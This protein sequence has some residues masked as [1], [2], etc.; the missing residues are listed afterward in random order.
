MFLK[1]VFDVVK[2]VEFKR[3]DAEDTDKIKILGNFDAIFIDVDWR[4]NL[5]DPI[6]KQ[7]I[8]PFKTCPRNDLVYRQLRKLYPSIPII[9]KVS[10]FVRVKD[11]VKLDPCVIEE[12]YIDGKFLSYN[13]YF[14]PK[15]KKSRWQEIHLY[16]K[17]R[18]K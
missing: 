11:M 12:L 4:E 17:D 9:L 18:T 7:N 13:V 5:S 3:L 14:D 16:N 1:E 2:N 15:I 10:P 8:N 6:K